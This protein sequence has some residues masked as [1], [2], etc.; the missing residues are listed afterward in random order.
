MEG[1]NF[2]EKVIAYCKENGDMSIR[3][4][5]ENCKL[6]NGVVATWKNR[7]PNMATLMKIAAKTGIP[8]AEW[9]S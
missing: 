5:E 2:Y 6:G 7:E 9:I 8:L 3:K 4:F 1:S